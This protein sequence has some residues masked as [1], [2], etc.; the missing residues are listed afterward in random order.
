M[1]KMTWT[2]NNGDNNND[3]DDDDDDVCV[4]TLM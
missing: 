2:V 3:D 1:Y 4:Y